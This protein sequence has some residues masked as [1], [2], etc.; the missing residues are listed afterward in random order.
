MV[1]G[2]HVAGVL[3]SREEILQYFPPTRHL[4]E[5]AS[6][7][8][9]S[10]NVRCL[11]I[12]ESSTTGRS[13]GLSL[14]GSAYWDVNET[15]LQ[16]STDRSTFRTIPFSFRNMFWALCWELKCRDPLRSY[17]HAVARLRIKGSLQKKQQTP[18]AKIYEFLPLS[19][20]PFDLSLCHIR[21]SNTT[22]SFLS[23]QRVGFSL[24]ESRRQLCS[25]VFSHFALFF[26]LEGGKKNNPVWGDIWATAGYEVEHQ[27]PPECLESNGRGG[28]RD[29]MTCQAA[30]HHTGLPARQRSTTTSVYIIDG[31]TD[32]SLGR[33]RS[34]QL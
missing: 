30:S 31:M 11:E 3:N 12:L 8:N 23:V 33:M 19:M 13:S 17:F 5:V 4:S 34:E 25:G 18:P 2:C 7:W 10:F 22:L 26:P 24:H 15:L 16:E 28:G 21:T 9:A 6:A 1:E 29:I 14:N 20:A 32:G 27:P